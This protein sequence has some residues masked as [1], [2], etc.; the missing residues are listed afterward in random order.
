MIKENE[1]LDLCQ[2]MCNEFIINL[3]KIKGEKK[4]I[5]WYGNLV[6]CLMLFF[7]NELPRTDKTQWA[8][9]ILVMK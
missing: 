3:W 9:D 4:G 1:K 2:W 8:F 6:V 5:F 7:L